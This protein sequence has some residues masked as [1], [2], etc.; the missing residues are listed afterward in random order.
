MRP[1][2]EVLPE[3]CQSSSCSLLLLKPENA[4]LDFLERTT[5]GQQYS[6]CAPR[7]NELLK[8]PIDQHWLGKKLF[9]EPLVPAY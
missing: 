8:S 2:L 5:L 3:A 1:S 4:Y 9:E 6:A 7:R